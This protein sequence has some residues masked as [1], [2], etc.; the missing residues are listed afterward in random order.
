MTTDTPFNRDIL[1]AVDDSDNARRAV[2]Y[3]CRML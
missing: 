1:I 2:A 3:V